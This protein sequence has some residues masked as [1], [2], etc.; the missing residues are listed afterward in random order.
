MR[1]GLGLSEQAIHRIGRALLAQDYAMDPS[2]GEF[3]MPEGPS[4]VP[5]ADTEGRLK[6]LEDDMGNLQAQMQELQILGTSITDLQA[7]M[8]ELQQSAAAP[9]EPVQ[10]GPGAGGQPGAPKTRQKRQPKQPQW[11]PTSW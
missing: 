9:H 6:A 4:N 11:Q 7:Q 5:L 8:Q 3:V 2:S 10:T 1:K